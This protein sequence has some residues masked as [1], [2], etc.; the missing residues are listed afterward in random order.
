MLQVGKVKCLFDIK[1]P[2]TS[3]W[4]NFTGLDVQN[5]FLVCHI[6]IKSGRGG[7]MKLRNGKNK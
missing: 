7:V 4:S 2:I 3:F 5:I 1:V 6:C